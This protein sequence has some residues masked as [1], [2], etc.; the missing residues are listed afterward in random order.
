MADSFFQLSPDVQRQALDRAA[1]F[2]GRRA[3]LLEKDVWVVWALNAVFS[4]PFGKHLVF[5]GGTSL[6]KA[7]A[8]IQ[9]FWVWI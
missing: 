9:R 5:E 4:A 2:T 1:A 6:S 7:Y 8:A 3:H